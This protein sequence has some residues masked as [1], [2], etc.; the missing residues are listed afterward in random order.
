MTA[1]SYD[2]DANAGL[3]FGLVVAAGLSTAV[4]A[5]AVYVSRLVQLAS[6]R[7]LACG[8]GFSAGVMLYVSFV[9]IIVKSH[10]SFTDYGMEADA[11]TASTACFFGGVL[12]M[13]GINWL[14]HALD[15]KHNHC[16]DDSQTCGDPNL[17]GEQRERQQNQEAAADSQ[18]V[19][20]ETDVQAAVTSACPDDKKDAALHRMGIDTAA[21]IAIHNFPEGLATFV[22][23]LA[24]PAVGATL[25]IAIAVHNVP[26][27]L[28]V[29]LPI[30][31]ATGSRMRG[32][33]WGLLSGLSEPVGALVGYGILKGSG[34]D[35]NQLVYGILF[36]VVAGMMV[37]IVIAELL[38]T[39][40]RYD[41]SSKYLVNSAFVGMLVMAL[42]LVM[43]QY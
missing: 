17:T 33:L 26:E 43:F 2:V 8:L 28:C 24:D 10:G 27:G 37:G 19:R 14:T 31:Y 35:L 21:A 32:F 5:A 9:E 1:I 7:V 13:K 41:P 18:D 16:M 11:Y 38:P 29:A 3:A 12:L 25:A 39:G 34:E 42:S 40:L 20:V 4:G 30:Y 36:G 15:S 6:K 23:T 22:A